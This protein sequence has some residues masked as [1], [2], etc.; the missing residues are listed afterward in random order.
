MSFAQS[1]IEEEN[2]RVQSLRPAQRLRN[3]TKT[4]TSKT[5]KQKHTNKKLDH[6]VEGHTPR[7]FQNDRKQISNIRFSTKRNSSSK[8]R[9]NTKPF[10]LKLQRGKGFS[11]EIRKNSTD[12]SNTD[13]LMRQSPTGIDMAKR[14]FETRNFEEARNKGMKM[15]T[16]IR[17]PVV[18]HALDVLH[19]PK[20]VRTPNVQRATPRRNATQELQRI[21]DSV[22]VNDR[23]LPRE[24]KDYYLY[25]RVSKKDLAAKDRLPTWN[26]RRIGDGSKQKNDYTGNTY[27]TQT[28]PRNLSPQGSDPTISFKENGSTT[29][30]RSSSSRKSASGRPNPW[31]SD[32]TTFV[33]GTKNRDHRLTSRLRTKSAPNIEPGAWGSL[34]GRRKRYT[35]QCTKSV[36]WSEQWRALC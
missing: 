32:P 25:G 3:E 14:D 15:S 31:K 5:T 17:T 10:S 20:A 23:K 4:F 33:P 8:E 16:Q 7:S 36:S 28:D 26:N 19:S 21:I 11:S 18:R 6:P 12:S 27:P 34:P 1:Y 30:L 35:G 29:H 9:T 22:E 2:T 13:R 24:R